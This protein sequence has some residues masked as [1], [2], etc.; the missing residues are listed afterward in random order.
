MTRITNVDQVLMLLRQQLQHMSKS[1]RSKR[2]GKASTAATGQRRPALGRIEAISRSD[3]L[4][5]DELARTLVG[6][7]L[8]DEFGEAVANDPKFQQLVGEVHRI[9]GSDTDSRRLL[10]DA[11]QEVEKAA[12]RAG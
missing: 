1:E 4:S 5:E 2:S 6:A 8:V 12:G 11:L 7:L 10:R 9:I 3:D